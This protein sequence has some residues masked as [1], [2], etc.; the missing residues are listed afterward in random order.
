MTGEE[1][2]K[3]NALPPEEQMLGV[4]KVTGL[5]PIAVKHGIPSA[6]TEVCLKDA[7]GADLLER[8]AQAAGDKGV[9]GTPTFFVNGRRHYGAYDLVKHLGAEPGAT[10]V[11][12]H[13]PEVM[14]RFPDLGGHRS[15]LA[16]RVG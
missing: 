6:K 3:L 12:G 10:V 14:A 16:V 11:P 7:A 13:D 5:I 4:A 8:A 9:Q 2:D 15:G 1:S